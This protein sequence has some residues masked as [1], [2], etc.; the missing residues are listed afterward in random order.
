MSLTARVMV[1]RIWQHHFG[2][3]LVKTPNDFGARG[4]APSHP[5][6]LDYLARRFIDSGWSVKT[7]HRLILTSEAYQRS[8]AHH[9]KNAQI[10]PGNVW[11]WKYSRRRLSA[12]EIRDAVLAV[13][14]DLDR[15]PA[16][17]HPFP[18]AKSWGYTQH[19][20]FSAVYDHD[21]RSVYL[22][23]Q[24]IKRHPFLALFDG[25]DA[26]ASTPFRHTTTVPTQSLFFLNDPFIHSKANSLATRLLKL[27]NDD[28]RSERA[29][30]LFYGRSP[31]ARERE[32]NRRFLDDTLRET[33][34]ADG[35]RNAWAGWLR[36]MF[37]SNEFVYVD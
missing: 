16:G 36:V 34:G 3:G 8:S 18:A 30:R 13:S 22:M 7:M 12:E 11:L 5:E 32:V 20:P 4:E 17:A 10:D 14:G 1:N 26:N 9:D 2:V 28:A 31:S 33:K 37:A 25:A 29:C 19:N 27:E 24:R 23:T 15:S 21:R 35:A 6:L